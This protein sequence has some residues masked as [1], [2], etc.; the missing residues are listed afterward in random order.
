MNKVKKFLSVVQMYPKLMGMED[1]ILISGF[2]A[3]D[4]A[5]LKKYA[6]ENGLVLVGKNG[7]A[8]T[9]EGAQMISDYV[10]GLRVEYFA[11]EKMSLALSKAVRGYAKYLFDGEELKPNSLEQA[12]KLQVEEVEF[13]LEETLF[14]FGLDEVIKNS[15]LSKSLVLTLV[16]DFVAKNRE[17]VVVYEK[18]EFCLEFSS[19]IFDK[20]NANPSSFRFRRAEV[21][22]E[23]LKEFSQVLGCR[24]NVI[25][26]TRKLYGRFKALCKGV[27]VTEELSDRAMRFRSTLL[28]AKDPLVL[29]ERDLC[30]IL[31]DKSGLEEVL[32]ELESWYERK[33]ERAHVFILDSFGVKSLDALRERFESV[34]KFVSSRELLI[35]GNNLDSVERVATYVNG[36]RCPK[37]W[38]EA[39][40]ADFRLRIKVLA[41]EFRVICAT[42]EVAEGTLESETKR[43]LDEARKLSYEQRIMLV[44]GLIG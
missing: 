12:V 34:R 8:L 11:D 42:V 9:R 30:A 6:V 40:S 24:V 33:L 38:D 15:G 27:M 32:A 5:K 2:S 28:N 7:I 26:F 37:D 3:G 17:R 44:R 23:L 29:F 36:K 4:L 41:A 21:E 20:M 10:S 18:E 14:D 39:D 1:R 16:M 43:L 25:D 35:L 19:L 13:A 22:N 31:K